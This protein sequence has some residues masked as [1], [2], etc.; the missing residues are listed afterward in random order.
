MEPPDIRDQVREL[1]E[2]GWTARSATLWQSPCGKLHVGPHGAWKAMKAA[3]AARVVRPMAAC[4]SAVA[5]AVDSSASHAPNGPPADVVE[6][7]SACKR[8]I[9]AGKIV[10]GADVVEAIVN[11]VEGIK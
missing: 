11:Y 9:A 5:N 2:N 8:Y 1:K 6:A 4:Q 3:A 10:D 7:A